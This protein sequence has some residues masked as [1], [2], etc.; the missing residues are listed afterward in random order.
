MRGEFPQ[1]KLAGAADKKVVAEDVGATLKALEDEPNR[2]AT[3]VMPD[4]SAPKIAS[5]PGLETSKE[6]KSAK[7]A[8]FGLIWAFEQYSTRQVAMKRRMASTGNTR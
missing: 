7:D 1:G 6:K 2:S 4:G 8:S 3:R 5:S